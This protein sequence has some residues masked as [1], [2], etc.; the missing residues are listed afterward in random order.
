L[1]RSHA[2]GRIDPQQGS[3]N[4]AAHPR[5]RGE[6][7]TLGNAIE[8]TGCT[9]ALTPPTA[10]SER[11]ADAIMRFVDERETKYV[12]RRVS[13]DV[14]HPQP[15]R[16]TLVVVDDTAFLHRLPCANSS[17][18]QLSPTR[19]IAPARLTR[20][21][22]H[23]APLAS[24]GLANLAIA[25]GA[26]LTTPRWGLAPDDGCHV[27][28]VFVHG[29]VWLQRVCEESCA[30]R[31]P[32]ARLRAD[33]AR[34]ALPHATPGARRGHGARKRA[35]CRLVCAIPRLPPQMKN[36]VSMRR[37]GRTTAHRLAM[38]R[39][40]VTALVTHGRIRTTLPK[41]KEV[42]PL[43]ERVITW[44][45]EGEC[46]R[47]TSKG[48][49]VLHCV[50][51]SPPAAAAAASPGGASCRPTVTA[52]VQAA[53]RTA[54][55][56]ISTPRLA[57]WGTSQWRHRV[58]MDDGDD[59]STHHSD[60]GTA[61]CTAT[62]DEGAGDARGSGA[63]GRWDACSARASASTASTPLTSSNDAADAGVPASAS[64]PT[65]A[66]AAVPPSRGLPPAAPS[67]RGAASPLRAARASARTDGA[68][69][70]ASVARPSAAGSLA[71]ASSAA[72][73]AAGSTWVSLD[74]TAGCSGVENAT[75]CCRKAL[76]SQP[77]TVQSPTC[78]A[79]FRTIHTMQP[80]LRLRW[81][82]APPCHR[83]CALHGPA[84]R[85]RAATAVV[86]VAAH[87]TV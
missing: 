44:G 32:W 24:T 59:R 30:A 76:G 56:A 36:R 86:Q 50:P 23:P 66:P 5:G 61:G 64:A 21:E 40:L 63:V 26:S 83:A 13:T 43:A 60:D 57:I 53:C 85:T 73:M 37:L 67:K 78:A 82:H 2:L 27:H 77:C 69:A 14:R 84:P 10:H 34:S 45:K 12:Q 39:N 48:W 51:A 6:D 75:T 35:G 68:R 11:R 22:R 31:L 42:R 1:H 7:D 9:H 47:A 18:R 19:L 28:F 16:R 62:C 8:R 74:A 55:P 70:S 79:R 80:E 54:P 20:S 87:S 81:Q 65:P 17:R 25:S 41:A 52:D 71:T 58:E 49:G 3:G 38:F 15:C 72:A 33:H 29:F 4:T 46:S